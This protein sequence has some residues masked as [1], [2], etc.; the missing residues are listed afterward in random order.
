MSL[1]IAT[2]LLLSL[3]WGEV[4]APTAT[5]NWS[6]ILANVILFASLAPIFAAMQTCITRWRH[7]NDNKRQWFSRFRIM[8]IANMTVWTIASV[9]IT[10][11]LKWSTVVELVPVSNSIPLADDLLLVGPS[12]LS[13]IAS[14]VILIFG[15]PK[16]CLAKSKSRISV[17]VLW[18]RMQVITVAAP[19][20]FAFFATDCLRL[21]ATVELSPSMQIIFMSLC[22]I[23]LVAS[24][25]F[26]P[27]IMLFVWS[28]KRIEEESLEVRC[29][30]LFELAG[31]RPRK[32]RVWKTGNSIVNAAAVGIVPGTEVI[33]VSDM[34]LDK[35]NEQEVDAILLHEIG[36]VRHRHSIKRIAMVLIPLTLLAIDQATGCG[37]HQ[38][39]ADSALL[40]SIGGSL[41]Q[42]LPAVAF[43]GYLLVMSKTVFRNMEFEADRFAIETLGDSNNSH[44]VESALEKMAVIYPRQ[45]DRRSGLHPS[46]RQRLAF[47]IEVQAEILGE[48]KPGDTCVPA[49]KSISLDPIA[50]K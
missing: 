40:N 15:A 50:V 43:M 41:T 36:H 49:P 23:V 44:A 45:V 30:K 10:T 1:L 24:I 28:T 3:F 12:L 39:I 22:S 4:C 7:S 31:I 27:Q 17:F 35:F 5:G 14:W 21:A 33:I 32:V 42:F 8:V 6:A 11:W 34:L 48:T 2:V 46:I 19:I 26:Y 37:L 38:L 20:L 16:G 13:L 47:A 9:S 25:L 29:H 18:L